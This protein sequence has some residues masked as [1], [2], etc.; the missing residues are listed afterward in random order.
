MDEAPQ[1]GSAQS[2][3]RTPSN[4][5]PTPD[6]MGVFLESAIS[7]DRHDPRALFEQPFAGEA[8]AQQ[9]AQGDNTSV[10]VM[11]SIAVCSN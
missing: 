3:T 11:A 8:I 6:G 10:T 5:P 4:F 7:I 9:S 2:E 1:P